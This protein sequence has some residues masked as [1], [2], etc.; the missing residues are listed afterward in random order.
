MSQQASLYADLKVLRADETCGFLLTT[1]SFIKWYHATGPQQLVILGEMGCGKSVAMAFLQ[2]HLKKRN[3]QLPSPK[4]CGYYC[5][6]DGTRKDIQMFAVLILSLL[7]QLPGLKK[8]FIAD[9]RQA[10]LDGNYDPAADPEILEGLLQRMLEGIDRPIFFVI[11]GLDECDRSSRDNLLRLLKTLSQRFSGF[12][13]VISFRP[14]EDILEQLGNTLRIE[15]GPDAERDALIVESAVEKQLSHLSTIVKALVINELSPRAC[16]SAIWTR[17]TVK[18]IQALKITKLDPMQVF[19]KEMPLPDD[20]STLY[21][22][23]L[24]Q[25]TSSITENEYDARTAL[26]LLSICRRPLSILELTWAVTLNAAR[27]ISTVDELSKRVDCQRVMS[28][29][30]PFINRVDFN[31]LKRHQ[32][33]LLHQSMKEFIL[34]EWTSDQPFPRDS[35]K[36]QYLLLDEISTEVLFSD[37]QLAI[38]ELPQEIDLFNDGEESVDYDPYCSWESWEEDMI[39][40]DPTERGFGEFF[41]YASSHWLDHFGAITVE[42]LPSLVS[43]ENLC[44]AGSTRLHNWTQQNCRPGCTIM[45]RYQFDSCLYDPLGITSL[46]GSEAML[47]NLLAKSDF[48]KMKYLRE[49]AMA[50]ADQIL[51]WGDVSRLKIIF[52][53]G[54]LGHQLQNLEF[55]RLILKRWYE[56]SKRWN[57]PGI[58]RHNWEILFDL[59]DCI[60]DKMVREKWGKDLLCAAASAGCV[61]MIQRLI[62]AA[63]KMKELQSEMLR[64]IE[65]DFEDTT[66]YVAIRTGHISIIDFLLGAGANLKVRDQG[67]NTPLHLAAEGGCTDIVRRLLNGSD[68]DAKNHAGKTALQIATERRNSDLVKVLQT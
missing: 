48:E 21:N 52:F 41:V 50:A 33:R 30:T 32:V 59:V 65:E 51:R 6:D 31:D 37:E 44:Q 63:H 17:M 24:S 8:P 23:L 42:P 68:K 54:N 47:Q 13:S 62:R 39:R 5:R 19:L 27:Y 38:A 12:K 18:L 60:P 64:G 43:V 1:E 34:K 16:G 3:D 67:G 11:D 45:P 29:I 57:K 56:P 66:L 10:Q 58:N 49:P 22:S 7:D 46:Y 4:I 25:Y 2:Q 14:Q 28:L 15:L 61:P 26:K 53:D 36:E 40:F 20:L 35:K 55:F 9:Y